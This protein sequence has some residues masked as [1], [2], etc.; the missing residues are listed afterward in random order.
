MPLRPKTPSDPDLIASYPGVDLSVL[1]P[2]YLQMFHSIVQEV[3]SLRG[4][5]TLADLTGI[6]TA[7]EAAEGEANAR[8]FARQARDEGDPVAFARCTKLVESQSRSKQAAL[9]RL[10][11]SG[12]RRGEQKS[13]LAALATSQNSLL[14]STKRRSGRWN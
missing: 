6:L 14:G 11:L 12:E 1:P 4:A 9:G 10:G 13:K 2:D 7:V 5:A 3:I 8:V